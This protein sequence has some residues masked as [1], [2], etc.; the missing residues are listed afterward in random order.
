[1][2]VKDFPQVVVTPEMFRLID[3]LDA[4]LVSRSIVAHFTKTVKH[5]SRSCEPVEGMHSQANAWRN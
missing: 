2:P 1:M 5:D 3:G 4:S